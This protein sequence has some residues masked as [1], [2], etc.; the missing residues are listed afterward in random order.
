MCFLV[1]DVSKFF[2]YIFPI[3]VEKK[4]FGWGAFGASKTV[5][6]FRT[7]LQRGYAPGEGQRSLSWQCHQPEEGHPAGSGGHFPGGVPER[8]RTL[9]GPNRAGPSS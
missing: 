2:L 6:K 5:R 3:F 9:Q 8:V 7:A 4:P 1:M